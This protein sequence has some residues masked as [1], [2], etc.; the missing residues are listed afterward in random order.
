[1][2]GA[3]TGC[4]GAGAVEREKPVGE[5]TAAESD[6]LGGERVVVGDGDDRVE[7]QGDREAVCG[8]QSR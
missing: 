8:A 5:E 3:V 7:A 4:A 1:V 6:L 2:I